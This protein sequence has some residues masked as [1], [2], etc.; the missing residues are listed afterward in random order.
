[1]LLSNTNATHGLNIAIRTLVKPGARV[2]IIG[3]ADQLPSVE[4]GNVLR[5]LIDSGAFSTVCLTEIFRQAQES[6]IV[7]NAHRVNRGEMPELKSVSSDFF[8]MRRDDV[9]SAAENIVLGIKQKGKY[10]LKKEKENILE[11]KFKTISHTWLKLKFEV[12]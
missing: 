10:D 12:L 1:M 4:A 5:D 7:M 6:L 9:F 8:F 3:D 11:I 2:I